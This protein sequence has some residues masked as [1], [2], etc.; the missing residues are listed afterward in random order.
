LTCR[1]FRWITGLAGGCA[2]LLVAVTGLSACGAPQYAYSADYAANTYFKV[3]Y[4]WHHLSPAEVAAGMHG[5]PPAGVW[6]SAFDAG[7]A[8]ADDLGSFVAESPFVL[9]EVFKL[10]QTAAAGL[11]YNGLEDA[12]L[13]VTSTARQAATGSS[14]TGFKL[15]N[16]QMLALGQGVHGVRDIFQYT[17]QVLPGINVVDT[18]DEVALTND[19]DTQVYLLLVHCTDSCYSQNQK[20]INDVMTSFTVRS[21]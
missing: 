15:L 18:F 10:N 9:A 11:S 8:S 3:P 14:L 16:H 19:I 7:K 13:P 6:T 2:L 17:D 4:G 21:P 5:A 1:S 12:F 20:A